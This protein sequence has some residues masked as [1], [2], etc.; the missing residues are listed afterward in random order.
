MSITRLIDLFLE[1][2]TKFYVKI[3]Y[4]GLVEFKFS[5]EKM[6]GVNILWDDRPI[7][8]AIPSVDEKLN[9]R[10]VYYIHEI[11]EKRPKIVIDLLKDIVWSLGWEYITEKNIEDILTK[12]NRLSKN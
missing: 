1:A 6:L 5:L 7:R 12:Y 3:G 4:W 2:S 8:N 10:K 11:R 9:W